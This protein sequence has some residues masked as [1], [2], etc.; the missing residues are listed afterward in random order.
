MTGKY[1]ILIIDD[2]KEFIRRTKTYLKDSY[3]VAES[4][5][6]IEGREVFL[7]FIPDVLLLD[8]KLDDG[9]DGM[10]VVK[11]LRKER[12]DYLI[13]ILVS[14]YLDNVIVQTARREGVDQCISKRTSEEELK[15]EISLAIERNLDKRIRKLNDKKREELFIEPVFESDAMKRVRDQVRRFMN[16]DENI[17]ITGPHGSGKEVLAS[18]IH[19]RS[20]RARGPY[21]TAGLPE[22]TSELFASE[23][24]GH[25]KGAFTS[26]EI[27]REGLLDLAHMGTLVLD[28]IGE[29]KYQLQPKLLRIVEHKSF[30]RVRGTKEI[31]KNVRFIALTNKILSAEVAKGNFRDDLFHRLKTFH[32]ELPP[33]RDR[34]EDIPVLAR[35]LLERENRKRRMHVKAIDS[36]LMKIMMKY[37]WQGNVRELD[38]WIKNGMTYVSGDILRKEDIPQVIVRTS[39]KYSGIDGNLFSASHHDFKFESVRLYLSRLLNRCKGDMPEAARIAGIKRE[40]LYRLCKKHGIKPADFRSG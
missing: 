7:N 33:L 28:E 5:G 11:E 34:T 23:F 35:Q 6:W 40:A 21:H 12:N 24:Y 39:I 29:L 22:L 10:D 38:E 2:D 25:V 30:R 4:K 26:A 19:Y 13:I 14:N 32:V 3:C 31:R 15:R 36:A 9:Y 18:W 16:L 8:Y 1:R 17:L 20:A 37:H 27:E